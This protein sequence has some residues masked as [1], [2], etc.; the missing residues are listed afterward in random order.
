MEPRFRNGAVI[1]ARSF[2][3]IHETNAKKQGLVPLTFADPATY[4]E[5]GEDDTINVLGPSAGPRSDR[6]AA[7]SSSPTAR[8]STSSAPTR[9]ATSRSSGSRPARR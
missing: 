5:I 3:R 1:F 4:D 9:S 2:A 8:R 6:C 7:R